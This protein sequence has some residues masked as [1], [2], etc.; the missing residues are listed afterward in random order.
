MSP[1]IEDIIAQT[2]VIPVITVDDARDAVPLC[3]ALAKGG[4]R[5]AEI[6]FRT[7]AA[8]EALTLVAR[9]LP[10]VLLGAGTVTTAEEA[11]AA[12]EAGARFALA[13]GCNPKVIAAARAAGMQ[14]FPGICTPSDIEMALE[15]GC[16][17][18]KFFPAEAAGGRLMLEAISTP[19][20]HRGVRFIPTG[21]ITANNLAPWLAVAGVMACAGT[22]MAP[23]S[24]ILAKDWAEITTLATEAV[25]L[26]REA[27]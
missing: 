7:A 15:A 4:L 9:E 18:L 11:Q 13:P 8:K 19:Y 16:T 21:G 24:R 25:A 14:F 17:T 6:T 10:E 3:R 1:T 23:Q 22:W 5:V 26:A 27:E 20:K 2:R 12:A